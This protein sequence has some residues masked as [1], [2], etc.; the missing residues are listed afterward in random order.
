MA[1]IWFGV[2]VVCLAFFPPLMSIFFYIAVCLP[3]CMVLLLRFR[4]LSHSRFRIDSLSV[5]S[6]SLS[7]VVQ[8]K[9]KAE[10]G[11][12]LPLASSQDNW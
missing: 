7:L 4:A 3:E 10:K 12:R 1:I 2:G 9:V 5:P 8:N 11:V 6:G